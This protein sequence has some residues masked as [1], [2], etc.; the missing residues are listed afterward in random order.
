MAKRT[1]VVASGNAGKLAEFEDM[2][3]SRGYTVR[4]QSDFDV[5]QPPETGKTFA[6]HWREFEGDRSLEQVDW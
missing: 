6:R 2:L 1:L 4:P 5:E 3:G